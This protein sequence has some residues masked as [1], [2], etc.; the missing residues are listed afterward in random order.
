MVEGPCILCG[1]S[2]LEVALDLGATALAN[3]FLTGAELAADREVRYPLRLAFCPGCSH[4]QLADPVP[5]AEMFSDYLYVSSAA[6]TLV[7]HL[8]ELADTLTDWAD[9]RPGDLVIDAGCNDGVLLDGFRRRGLHGLG[10]DPAEN[11][12]PLSRA[13]GLEVIVDFFG[14][15]VGREIRNGR[16]PAR[17]ITMTNT[18][19]HIPDLADLMRG[20]DAA[21]APDGVFAVQAHYAVDMFAQAA[22][23]TI[24]HEHVS[25][26]SLT[27][28]ARLF[29]RLG[30][31]PVHAA[32]LPIHHGQLRVFARRK[33]V[34]APD[35][36]VAA[37]LAAERE[38][39][40]PDGRPLRAF[41]EHTARVCRDLRGFLDAAKADGRRVAGYGAPAKGSTLL[42]TLGVTAAD[43]LWI[44]DISELKQGR[45][46][47]GS[48]IPIVPPSRILEDRPDDLLLL[49]WNFAEEIM[50]Q[51]A[52]YREGGGRFVLPLPEVRVL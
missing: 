17:A 14:E 11:L 7:E 48:H 41:A 34:S 30:F 29:D 39:G 16:G 2:G 20:V 4:I 40:L 32:R 15:R 50:R 31:E 28:M 22:F 19:P 5:P 52:A 12:A 24:Y 37:L 45:F 36:T 18:F 35:G 13:R 3:K 44:A 8:N 42:S 9:L 21:L 27:A 6:T 10:V 49:A 43:L 38:M 1:R 47:P 26:W 51:Q 23:D 25:Y 33:G 46:T